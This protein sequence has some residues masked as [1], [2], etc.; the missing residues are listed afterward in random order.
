MA[1]NHL[2]PVNKHKSAVM[3]MDLDGTITQVNSSAA[4]LLGRSEEQLLGSAY[5]RF[6]TI[7]HISDV[8]EKVLDDDPVVTSLTAE[9][10]YRIFGILRGADRLL[11]IEGYVA[12]IYDRERKVNGAGLMVEV[13]AMAVSCDTRT[14]AETGSGWLLPPS[15]VPASAVAY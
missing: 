11:A 15:Y 14:V 13:D 6:L 3:L 1:K 2:Q 10:P 7:A 8:A 9:T 4:Q 12:P 5:G